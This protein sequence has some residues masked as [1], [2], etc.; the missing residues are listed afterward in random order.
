MQ[1]YRFSSI[2]FRFLGNTALNARPNAALS[3]SASRA[4]A[5]S[6][7]SA[8]CSGSSGGSFGLGLLA[9]LWPHNGQIIMDMNVDDKLLDWVEG[10]ALENIRAHIKSAEDIKRESNTALTIIIAGGSGALAF[11]ANALHAPINIHVTV[12]MAVLSIYLFAL[13]AILVIRCLRVGSFPSPTNEPKNLYQKQYRLS[14]LREAEL[15]NIQRR[16]E[17]A[18][19]INDVRSLWLNRIWVA[20]TLSPMVFCITFFSAPLAERLLEHLF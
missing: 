1:P 7:N 14:R 20:A 9:I 15:K 4:L 19:Q 8:D 3:F 2:G 17:D 6:T 5:V 12:A 16:I 10:A 11:V 13:C 18:A